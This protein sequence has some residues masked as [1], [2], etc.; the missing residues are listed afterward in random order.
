LA[1]NN[2]EHLPEKPA[3]LG[4]RSWDELCEIEQW[5]EGATASLPASNSG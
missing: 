5:G 1:F 2:F 3:V 4:V